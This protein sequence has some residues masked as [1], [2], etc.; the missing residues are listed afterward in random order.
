VVHAVR[1]QFTFQEY[2]DLEE[3]SQVKHEFLDGVVWAMAGGSPDHAAI[4]AN[5]IGLLTVAVRDR[6]C[7][8]FTSDLRVRVKGTGLG[9]YP[10]VTVVC[11][12][13]QTDPDDPSG[14][15]IVNPSV[16]VEVLSKSTEQ[17]DRGEKLGHY[18]RVETLK[19]IVLLA[20]DEQR[21][22]V[23]RRDGERWTL[24]VCRAEDPVK[25]P[26]LGCELSL[27]ELYRDPTR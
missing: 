19:E 20:H 17:Y 18:Q 4:A 5:V 13:L 12:P 3:R 26:S 8:V 6:P 7:R 2:L 22:E 24:D 23:W 15:T 27:S 14:H 11:G 10:D 1:Q 25:L 16:V 21:A 9:T